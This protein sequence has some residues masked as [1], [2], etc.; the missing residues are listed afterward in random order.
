MDNTQPVYIGLHTEP[1]YFIDTTEKSPDLFQIKEFPAQ[2]NAGRNLFKL[3]GNPRNLKEESL[4]YIEILDYNGDPIAYEISDLVEEDESRI[5]V[6]HILPT[7]PSGNVTITLVGTAEYINGTTP[8]K[9]WA[10]RNNVMWQHQLYANP[11]VANS[12]EIIFDK[13]PTISISEQV[14]VQFDRQYNTTQ[15]VTYNS[16]S[17]QYISKNGTPILIISGGIFKSEMLGG[18]VT[19]P[20]PVNP[21][22]TSR[23][24]IPTI[25]YSGKIQ[26]VLDDTSIILDSNYVIESSQSISGVPHRY[27]QFDLSAYS[28]EYTAP[29]TDYVA[30]ENSESYALIEI[31]DLE[32]LSGD[33]SR[34]K[35][36]SSNTG[37]VGTWDLISD[38]E[39]RETDS[40]DPM[41]DNF[42]NA[43]QSDVEKLNIPEFDLDLDFR[44]DNIM[45]WDGKMVMVDW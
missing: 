42:L 39:L 24:T 5:I 8:P 4:L 19:V 26:R 2:L 32:P 21:V 7:T 27:D 41:L 36:F 13:K 23:Y 40:L 29:P 11:T 6:I 17:V 31:D 3:H 10:N 38:T 37:T 33:I 20:T 25:P 12:S 9:E 35:I 22:P 44:S 28:L 16:G 43:L 18:T 14:S 1:V 45:M 15:T 30:T 34:I